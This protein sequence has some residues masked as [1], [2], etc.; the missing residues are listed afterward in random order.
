MGR[1]ARVIHGSKGA[2]IRTTFWVRNKIYCKQHFEQ[3]FYDIVLEQVSNFNLKVQ[4]N[5]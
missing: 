2:Y 3:H 5:I 1:A 4:K